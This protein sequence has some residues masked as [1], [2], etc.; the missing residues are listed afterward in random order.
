MNFSD[1]QGI[2]EALVRNRS[3]KGNR[4]G[5]AEAN[6]ADS[7]K[8]DSDDT[9]SEASIEDG[10][11]EDVLALR[12]YHFIALTTYADTFE[13]HS[14]VQLATRIPSIIHT[15]ERCGYLRRATKRLR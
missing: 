9:E 14:L 15:Y 2:S 10:L 1:L 4:H 8:D 12:N 7:N 13:M 11:K 6:D 5:G 3:G